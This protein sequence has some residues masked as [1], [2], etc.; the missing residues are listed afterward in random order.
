[1]QTT[2]DQIF[3]KSIKVQ[4]Q[5]ALVWEAL[6]NVRLMR[7]WMLDSAVEIMTNWKVGSPISIK[8]ELSG[9]PFENKG[10]VLLFEPQWILSYSHLNSLS[11]LDDHSENY[12]NVTFNL[13]HEGEGTALTFMLSNFPTEIIYKHLVFYWTSTLQILKQFIE[14]DWHTLNA[15]ISLN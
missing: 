5:P 15:L 7:I 8:G 13:N 10:I 9:I 3:S 1:M 11:F 4:A 2:Y 14:Q 6:T 12:S